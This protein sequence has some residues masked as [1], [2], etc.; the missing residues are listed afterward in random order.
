MSIPETENKKAVKAKTKA[1]NSSEYTFTEETTKVS[2]SGI[3][4]AEGKRLEKCLKGQIHLSNDHQ[5]ES[6]IRAHLERMG[7]SHE[8]PVIKRG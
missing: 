7:V 6:A 8:K 2:I 5:L 4:D 1:E 3:T